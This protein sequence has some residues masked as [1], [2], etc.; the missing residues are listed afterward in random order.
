MVEELLSL[1]VLVASPST[2]DRDRLRQAAAAATVPIET[3]EAEDAASACRSLAGGIDLAFLDAALGSDE[4]ARIA[5]AV[6]TA[7]KA[8]FTVLLAGA[9]AAP[10]FETDALALKP[11]ASEEAKHLVAGAIR[12]RVPSRVLVV[13]DSPTMRSIVRKTLAATRFPLQVT[14][15]AQGADAIELARSA[16]F[17]IV[18]VDYNLPGFDGLETIAEFR[19]EKRRVIFVLITSTQDQ[20]LAVRARAQGA[21]FLKKPFFPADIEDVLCGFYGLR[22]LARK[23]GEG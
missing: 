10:S 14:E 2:D 11:M 18:F 19:R 9:R 22:A 21:A 1:R 4:V 13:D 3:I 16:V 6:R 12:L 15:A 23:R 7:P 17:D 5:A 20:A 8:P